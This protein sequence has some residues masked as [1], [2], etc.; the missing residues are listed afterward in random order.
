MRIKALTTL[1]LLKVTLLLIILGSCSNDDDQNTN[2]SLPEGTILVSGINNTWELDLATGT[3]SSPEDFSIT[4]MDH[5][6]ST[7]FYADRINNSIAAYNVETESNL[8]DHFPSAGVDE[9]INLSR[10]IVHHHN[11]VVYV[12]YVAINTVDFTSRYFL[13]AFQ[14]QTGATTTPTEFDSEIELMRASN[15]FLYIYRRNRDTSE[16][17]MEKLNLNTLASDGTPVNVEVAN[18]LAIIN[19]RP[20]VNFANQKIV[21]YTPNIVQ[22]WQFDTSAIHNVNAFYNGNNYYFTSRDQNLYNINASSGSLNWNREMLTNL[23]NV[24][25]AN[26]QGVIWWD[27]NNENNFVLFYYNLQGSEIWSKTVALGN[28]S[29]SPNCSVIELE[30][31]FL[32][33]IGAET[34]SESV[35][36]IILMNKSNGQTAWDTTVSSM[37]GLQ[38]VLIIQND[39]IISN[40]N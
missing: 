39:Q 17:V 14:A 13:A 3:L 29:E 1:N 23:G 16:I 9:T 32:L 28:L 26:Q 7:L 12:T 34:N 25:L 36:E 33:T 4:S 27:I 15:D 37:Q 10:S 18:H 22:D 20:V 40:N 31:H 6:G 35:Y 19:N 8:W 38:N 5:S 30:N 24:E 11:N 21:G 2:P